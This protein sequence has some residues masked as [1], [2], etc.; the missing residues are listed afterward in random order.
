MAFGHPNLEVYSL[1][2]QF[3][4]SG[5]KSDI[6]ILQRE[7]ERPSSSVLHSDVP[8]LLLGHF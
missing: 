1:T 5:W 3:Y 4:R 2:Y 7:T 6:Q 8:A